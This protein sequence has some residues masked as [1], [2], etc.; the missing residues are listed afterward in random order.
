MLAAFLAGPL[1]AIGA[2][3]WVHH[4]GTAKTRAQ[5]GQACSVQVVLLQPGQAAGP[6]G[7]RRAP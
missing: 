2:G 4:A 6:H 3:H 5:A 1:A 7:T